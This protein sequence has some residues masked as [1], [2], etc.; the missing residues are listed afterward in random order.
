MIC[1]DEIKQKGYGMKNNIQKKPTNNIMKSFN[2]Q[3]QKFM[4][5]AGGGVCVRT[6]GTDRKCSAGKIDNKDTFA[7]E[8]VK[9]HIVPDTIV[10]NAA[11]CFA[12]KQEIGCNTFTGIPAMA[13]Y[14]LIAGEALDVK[15]EDLTPSVIKDIETIKFG[16]K[17][18]CNQHKKLK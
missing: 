5:V 9:K 3:A 1:P 17:Q 6:F 13:I 11:Y 15:Q 8:A 14:S 10:Y 18:F 4:Q 12:D 2:R 7:F 16:M